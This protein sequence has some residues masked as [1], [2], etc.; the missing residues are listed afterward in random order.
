M[1]Y[2]KLPNIIITGTPGCGKTSHAEEFVSQHGEFTH[3]NVSE[4][5]KANGCI[6]GYD[7]ERDSSIVNEDK[8]LDLLEPLSE[9]GGLVIDWHCCE[10]F[11][12]RWID[13]VV[14]VRC[15]NTV[16]YERLEKRGYK[17]NKI[18]ENIQCEIMQVLLTEAM[19][20]Y[21]PSIVVELQSEDLNA[22]DDNVSRISQWLAMWKENN[23]DGVSNELN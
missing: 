18:T 22:L 3:I 15:D 20:N 16:L 9:K 17:Q 2:R 5:A 12:E 1:G 14:V 21:N 11:P 7:E 6:E 8:M 13:L 10:I 4:Y 23:P 19:E